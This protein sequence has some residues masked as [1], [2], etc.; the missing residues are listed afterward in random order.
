MDSSGNALQYEVIILGGGLAGLSLAI[1]LSLSGK[2]VLLFEKGSYPRHK[3]CGEYLSKES[4]PFLEK[5]NI[6]IPYGQLPQITK[7]RISAPDGGEVC[8]GLDMGGMGISR[9]LL[10]NLLYQKA[11][12]CGVEIMTGST[13][14]RYEKKE[15]RFIMS[16]ENR[17]FE[18][19]VLV[20][21][22]GRYTPGGFFKSRIRNNWIG[23]KY[24]IE[25]LH[26]RDEIVLH[27]FNGGYCGMSAIEGG[28]S[29]LCYLVHRKVMKRYKGN[30]PKVEEQVLMRNPHLRNIFSKAKFLLDKPEVISNINFFSKHPVYDGVFYIGDAAGSI[31]PLSGNGMSNAFRSS[32]LLNGIL[33]RYFEGNYSIKKAQ[34]EYEMQWLQ[35]FLGRISFGRKI[36]YLLCKERICSS[37]I[38]VLKWFPFLMRYIIRN[39]HGEIF[40]K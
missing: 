3:V 24:H 35:N 32:Y 12:E 9:Y 16:H 21:A 14:E 30:I 23:V 18:T 19:E 26:N 20:S 7:V 22:F 28:K 33:N 25:I 6:Q 40:Y 27:N 29:C 5:L 8:S 4:L 11:L 31:A 37:S 13:I 10:D 34:E 15:G 38:T 2:R 36:Q 17:V 39:T 1:Q